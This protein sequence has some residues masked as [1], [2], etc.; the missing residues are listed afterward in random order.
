MNPIDLIRTKAE[1]HQTSYQRFDLDA[2]MRWIEGKPIAWLCRAAERTIGNLN[3]ERR[4]EG[5]LGM[6]REPPNYTRAPHEDG[7]A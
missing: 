7:P 5:Y 6:K 2:F 3:N 1:R 4:Y